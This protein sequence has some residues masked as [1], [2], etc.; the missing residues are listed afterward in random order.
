MLLEEEQEKRREIKAKVTYVTE[1]VDPFGL[2]GS[3]TIA[4]AECTRGGST[5]RQ[6]EFLV[7]RG[8]SQQKAAGFTKRQASAVIEK[9]KDRATVKQQ[10]L[11]RKYGESPDVSFKEAQ[12]IITE[13]AANDWRPRRRSA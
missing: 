4:L 5:D 8:M 2:D 6:I 7:R 9:L 13:I 1:S 10:A 3:P 11:L 12:A